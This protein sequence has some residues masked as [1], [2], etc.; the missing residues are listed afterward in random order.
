MNVGIN[1]NKFINNEKIY[2]WLISFVLISLPLAHIINSIFIIILFI[3]SSSFYLLN[4]KNIK[5]EFKPIILLF[6]CIYILAVASLIWSININESLKGLTQKLS[7]LII[8]IIFFLTP[9][10]DTIKINE[11][12]NNFSIAIVFYSIYCLFLGFILFFKTG[13]NE[14]LFY[15]SLS[16]PLDNINA[17]YMS[18]YT[19]FALLFFFIKKEKQNRDF[20]FLLI[21]S[22]FLVLLSSKVIVILTLLLIVLS[23]FLIKK[24]NSNK[25]LKIFLIVVFFLITILSSRN[26]INRFNTEFEN[27]NA[28]EIFTKKEFGQV[29]YWT[30]T[31]LRLFQNRVFFELIKEDKII[32]KGYGID[33]SGS[34]LQEKYKQYNLYPG[35]YYYNFH[36][37]YLQIFAELGILGLLMLLTVFYIGFKNSILK[38]DFFFF[39]FLVLVAILCFT[40]S[41]LWRQRGM[42]F[43]IM[44]LLLFSK[45]NYSITIFKKK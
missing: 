7:F 27:T 44:I 9:Q 5:L 32:L 20:L 23:I 35:F 24:G 6:I 21:L 28:S 19:A 42:V 22:V 18:M 26:I 41:Y 1:L 12:F 11:I 38:K 4:K 34:K 25:K 43:F 8:P 45:N 10:F 30:G 36:N 39:S 40:E 31:S 33:T 29:Y 3:F 37:Q 2:L 16:Q 17:I 15:H 14:Y 13:N